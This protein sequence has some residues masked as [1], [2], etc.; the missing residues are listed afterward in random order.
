PAHHGSFF[1]ADKG[2]VV[3]GEFQNQLCVDRLDEPHVDHGGVELLA[4]L[5]CSGKQCAEGPNGDALAATTHNALAHRYRFKPRHDPGAAT[6][7][8]PITHRSGTGML[9]TG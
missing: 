1:D 3:P 9:E 5:Q 6:G 7:P 2:L 8:P 4:G